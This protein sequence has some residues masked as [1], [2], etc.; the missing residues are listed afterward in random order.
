MALPAGRRGVRPDQVKPDGTLNIVE[1]VPYELPVASADT[2]GGVKV[3]SGLSMDD[4]VLSATGYSLPTASDET[5]GGVKVGTGL[6]IADGVLSA[7]AQLPSHGV[8]DAGKVLSVDSEGGLDFTEISGGFKLYK[9]RFD[10]TNLTTDY[11]I[12]GL[13]KYTMPSP[14]ISGYTPV[15]ATVYDKYGGYNPWCTIEIDMYDAWKIILIST[16]TNSPS[17]SDFAVDLFYVKN[18]DNVIETLT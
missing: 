16:K 3:G 4:G 14:A 11:P 8:G 7:D 17:A 1:P 10:P 12:A 9:K 2:L 5:L 6:S 13:V 15:F 18:S